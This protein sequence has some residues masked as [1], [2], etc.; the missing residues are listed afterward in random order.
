M[1]HLWVEVYFIGIGWVTFDPSPA[2]AQAAALGRNQ[3]LRFLSRQALVAKMLWYRNVVSFDS[4][5]Q[6]AVLRN[7]RGGFFGFGENLFNWGAQR[8]SRFRAGPAFAALL[9]LLIM[10]SAITA[11]LVGWARATASNGYALTGDQARA[12]KLY[13]RLLRKLERAGIKCKGLAAEE[14]Q[15]EVGEKRPAVLAGASA[16]LL[17]YNQVRFGGRPL[18]PQPYRDLAK[19]LRQLSV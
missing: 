6:V 12:V 18:P 16:I 14:I 13:R 1:A 8:T 10:A 11:G 15:A 3:L 19:R 7:L 2:D 9:A 5:A 4:G 17:T